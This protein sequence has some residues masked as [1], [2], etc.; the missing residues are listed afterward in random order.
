MTPHPTL[1]ESGDTHLL[2][3]PGLETPIELPLVRIPAGTKHLRI[4]SLNLVG[5]T[6][7]NR[8]LG[9][10]LAGRI[11]AAVPDLTGVVLVTVVEKALQ[12]A[13]VVAD[14]LNIAEMAVAYNRVKPHM[15]ADLRPVVGVG[16]DSVTS[17]AKF[18]ALYERDIELLTRAEKGVIIVE[19][20]VST[21]ATLLGLT[22][23]LQ[24][25]MDLRSLPLPPCLGVFCVASEGT[26][27]FAL[28]GPLT[29]LATLPPPVVLA[30]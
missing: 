1:R 26:P 11:A 8:E 25:A 30:P 27:K 23:L 13:Q 3:V 19:D 15:E 14:E 10:L 17:G 6:R 18:L 22:D 12:L 5:Q 4:A 7:L 21:G 16:S 24:A 29:A 28:P 20:V 2:R 9:R